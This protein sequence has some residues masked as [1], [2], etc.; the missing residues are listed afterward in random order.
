MCKTYLS[1]PFRRAYIPLASVLLPRVSSWLKRNFAWEALQRCSPNLGKTQRISL[2]SPSATGAQG[3]TALTPTHASRLLSHLPWEYLRLPHVLC[4]QITPWDVALFLGRFC[5]SS[6]LW[7]RVLLRAYTSCKDTPWGGPLFANTGSV[8]WKP[9]FSSFYFLGCRGPRPPRPTVPP[10]SVPP[11]MVSP[12]PRSFL[13]VGIRRW[14]PS[15]EST[16]RSEPSQRPRLVKRPRLVNARGRLH[17][18]PPYA[19]DGSQ[20]VLTLVNARGRVGTKD[21]KGSIN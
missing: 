8:A 5:P 6:S 1:K 15:D 13:P 4:M 12:P 7:W 9:H 14:R 2:P 11:P 17:F 16:S 20:Q 18:L 21:N 19:L 10:P 3:V